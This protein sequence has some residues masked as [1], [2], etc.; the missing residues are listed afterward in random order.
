MKRQKALIKD[1]TFV[2]SLQRRFVMGGDNWN[3][4]EENNAP[5]VERGGE[6]PEQTGTEHAASHGHDLTCGAQD[7]HGLLRRHKHDG[8]GYNSLSQ[9]AHKP[10]ALAQIDRLPVVEEHD[11]CGDGYQA[12]Q[13]VGH[14][15]GEDEHVRGPSQKA[16]LPDQ[17]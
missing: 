14:S 9:V 5:N 3:S 4:R 11:V 13:E 7:S 2:G 8:V 12:V 1:T 17:R 6:E 15:D 10:E 16:L